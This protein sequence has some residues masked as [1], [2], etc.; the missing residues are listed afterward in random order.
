MDAAALS[1]VCALFQEGLE[2]LLHEAQ[3][4]LRESMAV[5]DRRAQ[6]AE[7]GAASKFSTFKMSCGSIDDFHMGLGVRVGT[8]TLW[9]EPGPHYLGS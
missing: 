2:K 6:E 9:A 4:K 7:A 1:L 8:R 3:T 5:L